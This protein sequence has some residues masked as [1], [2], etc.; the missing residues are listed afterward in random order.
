MK[1][2]LILF[3]SIVLHCGNNTRQRR[4]TANCPRK[5]AENKIE[6]NGT[7]AL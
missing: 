2:L 3:C 7:A 5:G 6:Y 1:K 4:L